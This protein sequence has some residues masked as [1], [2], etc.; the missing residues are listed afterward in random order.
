MKERDTAMMLTMLKVSLQ[1][2]RNIGLGTNLRGGQYLGR[3]QDALPE[4]DA[5]GLD[6]T[7]SRL[8]SEKL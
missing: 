6:I 7:R 3:S 4:S 8:D 1:L 5:K 2:R